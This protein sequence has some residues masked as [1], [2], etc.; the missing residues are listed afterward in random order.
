M[1]HYALETGLTGAV[2]AYT[3]SGL[4]SIDPTQPALAVLQV[5]NVLHQSYTYKL[6]FCSQAC[7]SGQRQLRQLCPA[8]G[9]TA[10]RGMPRSI[11]RLL[12]LLCRTTIQWWAEGSF[13]AAQEALIAHQQARPHLQ[14][15]GDL[16]ADSNAEAGLRGTACAKTACSRQW[17]LW[18]H[19]QAV[20]V[21]PAHSKA[22]GRLEAKLAG[23][24]LAGRLVD[25][26]VICST[27]QADECIV[28]IPLWAGPDYMF[29]CNM[30]TGV[31]T[32]CRR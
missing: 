29:A 27:R 6:Q 11:C 14:P 3:S 10:D 32:C 16:S 24:G 26:N 17:S 4:Q 22:G 23:D 5:H 20:C 12:L 21:V 9:H 28:L 15:V 2:R 31:Y 1:L 13:E 25:G 18:P 19:L 8:Q 30:G 7:T